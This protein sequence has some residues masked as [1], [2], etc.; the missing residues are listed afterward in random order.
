MRTVTIYSC[1]L[2][3][4]FFIFGCVGSSLLFRL[5]SSCGA[6]GLL[7]TCRVWAPHGCGFSRC[8]SRSLEHRLSSVAHKLGCST[9]CGI[10]LDQGLNPCLMHWQA[11]FYHWAT[12]EAPWPT[13]LTTYFIPF[14]CWIIFHCMHIPQFIYLFT[15][16]GHL[17]CCHFLD[18]VNNAAM[19]PEGFLRIGC[20]KS[21]NTSF[22]TLL[23]HPEQ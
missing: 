13:L 4:V 12:R 9:A 17:G 6:Q 3:T 11:D 8:S 18:L 22:R 10:F 7:A 14:Y 23:F 21:G 2:K 15:V 1:L 5:F 16:K 20:N 19:N